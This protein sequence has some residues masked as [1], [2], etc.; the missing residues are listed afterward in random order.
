MGP[1]LANAEERGQGGFEPVIQAY[2]PSFALSSEVNR[3]FCCIFI[4]T[5]DFLSVSA[6]C[7]LCTC[8][9]VSGWIQ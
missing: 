1:F 3:L 2:I 5:I 6:L 8:D 9:L 7:A 4:K